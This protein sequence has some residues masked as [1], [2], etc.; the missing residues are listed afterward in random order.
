MS[1]HPL[2]HYLKISK[3]AYVFY[4][5]LIIPTGLEMGLRILGYRPFRQVD[6]H[7]ESSPPNCLIAHPT[8]GFALQPGDFEVTINKG[9]KYTVSHGRDS[10]RVSD[11]ST[12]GEME[13][14]SIYFF[15]C[16]YTYGMGVD[17]SLVFPYLVS[18]NLPNSLVKNFGVPGYGTVQT[19]LQ[20]EK[21]ITAGEIPGIAII[22]YADFHDERN[23]LTA[24][25]RR[26]LY[27]G[28]Q[29]SNS[30]VRQSM[31]GSQVP[32]LTKKEDEFMI[33]FCSWDELYDHWTFRETFALVNFFQDW[34]DRNQMRTIDKDGNTRH[35]FS[36]I[37][38]LC[39]QASI[40]LIVTGL[41][42]SEHTKR[43]LA[44]LKKQKIEVLDMSVDLASDR[45]RNAP[46]DDHPNQLAHA[47]FAQKITSYLVP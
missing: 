1:K 18:R 37:K 42:P 40:R 12:V 24:L 9:L 7:I 20:L 33:D 19:L 44:D 11:Y 14:D 31:G 3:A 25:Y 29:R 22:N 36:V 43:L 21:L 39:E 8:L 35:L 38:N 2:I 16:S 23:S 26:D 46:Y 13:E 4:L 34:D 27:M 30:S 47:I 6:Y 28:Y 41:T 10:L 32:F 45:Y 5:A 17:D 15:G